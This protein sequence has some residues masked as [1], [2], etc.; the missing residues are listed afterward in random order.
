MGAS[1]GI[2][3]WEGATSLVFEK[4]SKHVKKGQKTAFLTLFYVLLSIFTYFYGFH[5]S[6]F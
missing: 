1:Q 6:R 5:K 2:T 3:A 4:M